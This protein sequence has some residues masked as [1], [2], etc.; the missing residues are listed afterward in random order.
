MAPVALELEKGLFLDKP[1]KERLYSSNFR[2][3]KEKKE[4]KNVFLVVTPLSYPPTLAH[5]GS[6]LFPL[7]KKMF[8]FA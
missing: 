3:T 5:S 8:F 6:Y 4:E 2:P 1:K 7:V